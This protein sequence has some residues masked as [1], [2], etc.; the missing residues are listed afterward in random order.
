M[1]TNKVQVAASNFY[2]FESIPNESLFFYFTINLNIYIYMK[3]YDSK[4][5][6]YF[7]T[8]QN[9]SMIYWPEKREP[10][11]TFIYL[12][13]WTMEDGHSCQS[14]FESYGNSKSSPQ[15]SRAVFYLRITSLNKIYIAS[16][17]WSIG[18]DLYV[19]VIFWLCLSMW[20]GQILWN[21]FIN[22]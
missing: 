6:L 5:H 19:E 9:K 18:F 16:L 14:C 8:I 2:T 10:T 1:V 11:Q 17:R 15:T 7:S 3:N 4:F 13:I 21:K 20:H 12:G 22:R